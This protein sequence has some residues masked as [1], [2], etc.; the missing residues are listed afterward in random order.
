MGRDVKDFT[1]KCKKTFAAYSTTQQKE[2]LARH[3]FPD[4]PSMP[5]FPQMVTV[6]Y[7]SSFFE[8]DR[9]YDLKASIVIKKMKV[10][11]AR[12]GIRVICPWRLSCD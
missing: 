6:D 4:R 8:V 11:I 1:F 10:H 9:L 3:E 5:K 2:P 7:F 12:Y